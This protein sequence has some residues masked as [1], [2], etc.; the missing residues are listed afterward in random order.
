MS[1][2]AAPSLLPTPLPGPRIYRENHRRAVHGGR[3]ETPSPE[4]SGKVTRALD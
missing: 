3:G 4:V 1:H 2:E